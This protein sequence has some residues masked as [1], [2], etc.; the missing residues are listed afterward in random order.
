[1]GGINKK[2]FSLLH[3]SHC[4]GESIQFYKIEFIL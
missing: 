2:D 4:F 3:S 1:M